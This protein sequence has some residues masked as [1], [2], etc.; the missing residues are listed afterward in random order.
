[1]RDVLICEVIKKSENSYHAINGRVIVS[2]I[3]DPNL[4]PSLIS[5]TQHRDEVEFRVPPLQVELMS[6]VMATVH[7]HE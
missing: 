4:E 2:T 1:M 5:E 3:L 7:T 6:P